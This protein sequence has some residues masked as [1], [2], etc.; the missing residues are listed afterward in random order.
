M[1]AERPLPP[2]RVLQREILFIV[3]RFRYEAAKRK[4]ERRGASQPHGFQ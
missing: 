1:T 2:V 3:V 4:M